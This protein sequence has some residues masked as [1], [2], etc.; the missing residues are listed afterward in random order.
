MDWAA[1][2]EHLQTVFRKFD[3]NAVILEPVLIR[4]FRD[5]LRPSIRAQAK[6]KGRQKDTWD[7]V[8]RK[9]ITAKAKAALNLLF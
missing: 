5:S 3:A 4:L 7:Q 6:Q 2:L 9:A 1:Y 8:M